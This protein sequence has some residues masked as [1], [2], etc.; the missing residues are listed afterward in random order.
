V[1]SG[2]LRRAYAHLSEPDSTPTSK[3]TFLFCERRGHFYLWTTAIVAVS[4]I[5]YST[6]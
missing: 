6:V 2:S 3:G 5:S 4:K 1:E